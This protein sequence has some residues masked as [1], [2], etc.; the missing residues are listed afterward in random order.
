[1]NDFDLLVEYI[2]R[3]AGGPAGQFAV[4]CYPVRLD[5]HA[6]HQF[7]LATGVRQFFFGNESADYRPELRIRY[8]ERRQAGPFLAAGAYEPE[9][10]TAEAYTWDASSAIVFSAYATS[11]TKTGQRCWTPVGVAVVTLRALLELQCEQTLEFGVWLNRDNAFPRDTRGKAASEAKHALMKGRLH[12]LHASLPAGLATR[13]RQP[14]RYDVDADP[15]IGRK[16]AEDLCLAIDRGMQMFFSG[17]SN[18]P[19][20]RVTQPYLRQFNVPEWRTA[21]QPLP[22]STYSLL[23]PVDDADPAYFRRLFQVGLRRSS[24]TEERALE[25]ARSSLH[26]EQAAFASLVV[27]SLCVYP[28]SLCY[29]DDALN[30]NVASEQ[31]AYNPS[32]VEGDEDFKLARL[33]GADDCEGVALD[34]HMHFRQ[35][36]AGS[37]SDPL[38]RAAAG[39]AR[40]YLPALMLGCVTNSKMTAAALNQSCALAHTFSAWLPRRF[41]REAAAEQ[42]PSLAHFTDGGSSSAPVLFA[43]ATAPIDPAMLPVSSYYDAAKERDSLDAALSAARARRLVNEM[44]FGALAQADADY[45]QVEVFGPPDNSG[46][47]YS[48][49]YKY[50]VSMAVSDLAVDR[51][52][53]W[54]LLQNGRSKGVAIND[55]LDGRADTVRLVP[56]ITLSE[57]EARL[58]DAVIADVQPLPNLRLEASGRPFDARLTQALDRLSFGSSAAGGTPLHPRQTFITARER[59]VDD[60]LLTALAA[61]RASPL[62]RSFSYQWHALAEPID[63]SRERTAILD[64]YIGF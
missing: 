64:V 1:M 28:L 48:G 4:E 63:G 23:M 12:V 20:S 56:F 6:T 22:A 59:D 8:H 37:F 3:L 14:T 57:H 41:F 30:R 52:L 19:L 11:Y 55:L 54:V 35:L 47:D 9:L 33:C 7:A 21:R 60:R 42:T 27:R 39:F 38:L 29:M 25:L 46:T 10:R 49:F 15:E 45:A 43:E 17:R 50:A 36:R 44:I 40:E 32:L 31:G 62:I 58:C 51:T 5:V 24:L 16:V 26:F 13:M 2:P 34:V 18:D 53:D 61:I